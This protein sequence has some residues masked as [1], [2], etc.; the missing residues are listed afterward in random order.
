LRGEGIPT[1]AIA[2]AIKAEG[3]IDKVAALFEISKR[4][5]EEAVAFENQLQR[6]A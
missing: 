2:D 3:S 1:E 4:R 5:V 6:A